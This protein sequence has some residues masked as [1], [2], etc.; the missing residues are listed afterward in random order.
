ME[1][2]ARTISHPLIGDVV[3]F[4]KTA[5]ETNEEYTLVEVELAPGGGNGL[6]Y[7]T[8][9]VEHFEAING[10]LGVQIGKDELMLKPGETYTVEKHIRHRFFNPDKGNKITFKVKVS[11]SRYFEET[12]RIAYGLAWDGKVNKQGIPKSIWH[13]AILFDKGE[14]YLPGIPYAMQK[15]I[16]GLL[17]RLAVKLGKHRELE[18]YC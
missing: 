8:T 13:M 11:P 5:E 17:A 4:L 2:K 7:H 16:F 18:K 12:L 15:S 6:H 3:T 9:F 14:T 10:V 1:Q